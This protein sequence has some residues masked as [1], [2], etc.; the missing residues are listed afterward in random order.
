LEA[1]LK[2]E[3]DNIVM[4]SMIASPEWIRHLENWFTDVPI[5]TAAV[6]ERL[7]EHKAIFPGLGDFGDRAYD[8]N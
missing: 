7:N 8:T 3:P 6:D 1:V 5:Y 2:Q 4:V